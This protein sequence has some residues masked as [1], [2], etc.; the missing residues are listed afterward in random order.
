MK[1][2]ILLMIVAI[3]LLSA[4]CKKCDDMCHPKKPAQPTSTV[5]SK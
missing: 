3:A 4:S 5:P 2:K 1:S